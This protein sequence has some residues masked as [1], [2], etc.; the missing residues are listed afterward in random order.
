MALKEKFGR[1][2][3]R[4]HKDLEVENLK[5]RCTGVSCLCNN[6]IIN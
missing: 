4:E 5:R 6:I 2:R 1:K 3:P